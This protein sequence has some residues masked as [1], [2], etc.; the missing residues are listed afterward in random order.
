M[1][2][3]V[4]KQTTPSDMPRSILTLSAAALSDADALPLARLSD[5][6]GLHF[7]NVLSAD[8]CAAL[9]KRVYDA[10]PYWIS[11]FDGVQFSLG[12]AWYT[13]LEQNRTALYF[14]RAT[15]S[16]AT[17]EHFLPA[18]QSKMRRIVGCIV[19]EPV[20]QR[21][22]WCG[23]GVHIFPA[24]RWL[25]FNGG[26]PHFDTEGLIG[27]ALQRRARA[28]T[29]VLMLQ[30][31]LSGGGLRI[32]ETLYTASDDNPTPEITAEMTNAYSEIAH[33]GIGD[34]LVIDS[35]QLHQIQPFSGER[36]RISITLHA[37]Q[38]P[39]GWETWF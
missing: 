2:A 3:A 35:Y 30:P 27:D 7:T 39:S 15:E 25:S 21:V 9:V 11:D 34:L 20:V 5:H 28:I 38:T 13:H 17:V 31:P 32:W 26:E 14:S 23:A 24:H 18:M 4:L 33:Y 37:C 29:L 36:D 22:G 6:L 16:N 10:R 8:T 1:L 19:G 12:R